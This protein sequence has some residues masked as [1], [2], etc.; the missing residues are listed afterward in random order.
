MKELVEKR[1]RRA[2]AIV[3]SAAEKEDM[4]VVARQR[5]RKVVMDQFNDF[6]ALVTDVL[7]S[8]EGDVVMNE[9][10]LE[11]LDALHQDVREVLGR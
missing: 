6:A 1:C 9:L 3:L 7:E 10:W 5:L 8:M 11:K 4:N 2:I